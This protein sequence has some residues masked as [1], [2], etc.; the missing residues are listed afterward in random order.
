MANY[1]QKQRS[2]IEFL[3]NRGKAVFK[4][5]QATSNEYDKERIQEEID[6]I[7][8]ELDDALNAE[9]RYYLCL[10]MARLYLEKAEEIRNKWH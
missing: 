2:T 10:R 4:K 9:S 1:T 6:Y 8:G 3:V 7:R 5:L